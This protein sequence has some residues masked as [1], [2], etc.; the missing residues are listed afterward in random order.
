MGASADNP[1]TKAPWLDDCWNRIGVQGDRTCPRLEEVVHCVHCPVY[2]GAGALLFEREAPAE[3]VEEWTRRLAEPAPTA[4]VETVAVLVFRL[5]DEWLAIPVG[6]LAEVAP[7]HTIHRV[8]HRT[9]RLLLGLANIRGE[10]QLCVSLGELLGIEGE[11]IPS[12]GPIP[13]GAA[14]RRMLV[15]ER[16][17]GRWVFPVD[18]V[19]G[20]HRVP[21]AD[22]AELPSTVERSPRRY[23]RAIF[24][25][26]GRKIGL[27]DEA[28]L[29]EALERTVR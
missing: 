5:A 1:T 14:A 2:A 16:D 24:A 9:D 3:Y 10:L 23:C 27:L 6:A 28:R 29:F 25:L 11:A 21:R 22:L 18:E 13:A 4:G 15:A 17:G 8:P 7:P 12:S 26:D 20:V 19:A